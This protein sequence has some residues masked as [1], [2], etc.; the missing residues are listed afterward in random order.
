[1]QSTLKAH[2]E[3]IDA[4]LIYSKFFQLDVGGK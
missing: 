4:A 3:R 1:M 2:K